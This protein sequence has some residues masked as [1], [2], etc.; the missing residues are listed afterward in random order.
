VYVVDDEGVDG[1]C[2]ECIIKNRN[3][4]HHADEP[5][6]CENCGDAFIKVND[7]I[8]MCFKCRERY[9][10]DISKQDCGVVCSYCMEGLPADGFTVCE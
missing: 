3:T 4:V 9:A 5:D 10:I 2:Y 1:S 7:D 6:A 8:G